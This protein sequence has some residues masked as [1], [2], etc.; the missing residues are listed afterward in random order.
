MYRFFNNN[1]G[2]HFFTISESEKSHGDRK[3]PVVPLRGRRFLRLSHPGVGTFPVYRFF[4]NNA[5][6]HFFTISES[7]KNTVIQQLQVVPV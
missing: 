2:G 4:N 7:E 6:G 1:A 5:G 3:L